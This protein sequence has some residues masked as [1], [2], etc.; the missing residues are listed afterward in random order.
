MQT[1]F[2]MR[3]IY[4]HMIDFRLPAVFLLVTLLKSDV[5]LHV[6][7]GWVVD[8][9]PPCQFY[10]RPCPMRLIALLGGIAIFLYSAYCITPD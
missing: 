10:G 7:F 5:Y 9:R 8:L 2:L 1:W 4:R 3:L 6:G